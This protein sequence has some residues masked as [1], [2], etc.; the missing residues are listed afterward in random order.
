MRRSCHR[1][2]VVAALPN[3]YVLVASFFCGGGWKAMVVSGICDCNVGAAR[4]KHD[5]C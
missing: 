3:S 4:L 2:G 5:V 1:V